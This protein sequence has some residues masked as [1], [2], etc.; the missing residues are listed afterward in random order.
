MKLYRIIGREGRVTIP[1]PLR[2]RVGFAPSDVVSFELVSED[3]V[4]VRREQLRDQENAPAEMPS[5]RE[6]L[7]CLTP[8]QQEAARCYLSIQCSMGGPYSRKG[9]G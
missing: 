5:L 7:E 6:L 8:E 2:A 4:L 3:A 9:D 1:W